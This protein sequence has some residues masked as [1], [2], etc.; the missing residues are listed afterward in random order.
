MIILIMILLL[1]ILLH[2]AFAL[3]IGFWLLITSAKLE[4]L[5]KSL[6]AVFGWLIIALALLLML[7]SI[8]TTIKYMTDKDYRTNCPMHRMMQKENA[9]DDMDKEHCPNCPVRSSEKK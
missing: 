6:G 2:I 3:A 9:E 1:Y 5:F 7:T 8:V 4:G